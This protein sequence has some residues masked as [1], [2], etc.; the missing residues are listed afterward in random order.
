MENHF[1]YRIRR[2][3]E[4]W[5]LE[6]QFCG[7]L[8]KNEVS[9]H[10]EASWMVEKVYIKE[11]RWYLIRSVLR[12][13]YK[14]H[15]IWIL[16]EAALVSQHL[17]AFIQTT[18]YLLRPNGVQIWKVGWFFFP[19]LGALK[20]WRRNE[21]KIF[22]SLR[23]LP[24]VIGK[25]RK[26]FLHFM[27]SFMLLGY[28]LVYDGHRFSIHQVSWFVLLIDLCVCVCITCFSILVNYKYLLNVALVNVLSLMIIY[29]RVVVFCLFV[30]H[31]HLTCL[32][33]YFHHGNFSL[34]WSL[35]CLERLSA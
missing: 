15:I 32:V 22:G 12:Y 10:Y 18:S 1:T 5:H 9:Q 21:G 23:V 29:Y 11:S 31:E 19:K 13:L 26:C 25:I 27:F 6:A 4:I 7:Y 16:A 14:V 2:Y 3:L 30:L 24:R 8:V 17:H 34:I 35:P 33:I 20:I 28:L